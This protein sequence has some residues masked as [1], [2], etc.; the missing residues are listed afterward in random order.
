MPA[1]MESFKGTEL[2][3]SEALEEREDADS[4]KT[5]MELTSDGRIE[6]RPTAC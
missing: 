5:L 6:G 4:S 1:L 2:W 3:Q